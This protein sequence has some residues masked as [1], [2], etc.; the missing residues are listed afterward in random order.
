MNITSEEKN[1]D[2]SKL[3]IGVELECMI[4]HA[5]TLEDISPVEAQKV[6]ADLEQDH[7]W[8]HRLSPVKQEISGVRKRIEGIP[9]EIKMDMSYAI[10][11]VTTIEPVPSLE[12]LEKI[13]VSALGELREV[14]R[15]NGL[16]I[17]P[18]G[19]APASNG[20]LRLPFKT[21]TNVIDDPYYSIILRVEDMDRFFHITSHQMSL[22]IPIDKVIPMV[23]ALFKNLGSMI[24]RFAN[25]PVYAN[26]MLYKEGRYYWW[27]ESNSHEGKPIYTARRHDFP[28]KEFTNYDDFFAWTFSGYGFV[29]RNGWTYTFKDTATTIAQFLKEKKAIA[30]DPDGK[31]VKVTLQKEDIPIFMRSFWIDFKPHFELDDTFTLDEFLTAYEGGTLTD[32]MLKHLEHAYIECRPC[33]PHFENNAMDIPRYFYDIFSRYDTYIKESEK[34]RWEQAREERDRAIGY[35]Q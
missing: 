9:V 12:L 17:W 32:F 7:A 29:I 6:F 23:N 18:L 31:E 26:G 22:D 14:L 5:N 28:Q 11:E 24:K 15:E 21:K 13:H 4:V 2:R 20:L 34:I 16:M 10:F 19:V 27:L 35:I 30:L 8:L 3:N 33:A 1:I 25:S